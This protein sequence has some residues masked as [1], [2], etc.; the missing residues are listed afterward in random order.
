MHNMYN[1]RSMSLYE[2][3]HKHIIFPPNI[4]DNVLIYSVSGQKNL[5]RGFSLHIATDRSGQKNFHKSNN[6]TIILRVY[7]F[8]SR[9][10]NECEWKILHPV[11]KKLPTNHWKHVEGPRNGRCIVYTFL[12]SV[13]REI[14]AADVKLFLLLRGLFP[15][16]LSPDS[17][18]RLAS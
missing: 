13:E 7:N 4:S 5:S 6:H 10:Y 14:R 8:Q 16:V 12:T 17:A 2:F 15:S 18:H 11:W 3:G 9:L 1:V